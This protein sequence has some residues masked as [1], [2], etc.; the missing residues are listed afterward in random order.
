MMEQNPSIID[1]NTTANRRNCL[2]LISKETS[3]YFYVL[4]KGLYHSEGSIQGSTPAF[5]PAIDTIRRFKGI[6]DKTR[7]MVE[8]ISRNGLGM[9]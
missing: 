4:V 2:Q 5:V 3:G 9:A 6:S 7:M 8:R 1:T